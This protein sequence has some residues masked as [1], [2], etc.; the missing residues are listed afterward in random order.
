MIQGEGI[1]LSYL[2]IHVLKARYFWYRYLR[3]VQGMTTHAYWA[4]EITRLFDTKALWH[5]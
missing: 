5:T 1:F 4:M 3:Q 2:Q